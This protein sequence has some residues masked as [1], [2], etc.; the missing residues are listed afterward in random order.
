M[1]LSCNYDYDYL[2]PYFYCD[3]EEEP[4]DP[5]LQPA[6]PSEDIWKKFQLLPTPP[7]TLGL[8]YNQKI[9]CEAHSS[10]S[11]PKPIIHRD[12]MWSGFSAPAKQKVLASRKEPAGFKTLNSSHRQDSN[13]STLESIDPSV[14]FPDALKHSA[15]QKRRPE[16]PP[17]RGSRCTDS[18]AF[19]VIFYQ[20]G[21]L[22]VLIG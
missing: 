20:T 17:S 15:G 11:F 19:V 8:G 6:V 9:T 5:Q 22:L 4:F 13:T 21:S 1:A 10:Q 14:I 18:G 2:Q 3:Q 16:A 12:C 7:P